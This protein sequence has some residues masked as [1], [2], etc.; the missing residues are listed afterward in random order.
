MKRFFYFLPVMIFVVYAG[1]LG[2]RASQVPTDTDIINVYAAQYLIS[3][4]A[5]ARIT[6]CS[7]RPHADEAIRMVITC[8]DPNGVTTTYFV[9]PRGAAL[10]EPGGPQV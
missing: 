8:A 3:A 7:A 9:G 2:F 10:P 4:S 6:D 5:D 1:Y